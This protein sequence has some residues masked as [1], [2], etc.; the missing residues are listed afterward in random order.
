MVSLTSPTDRDVAIA[1]ANAGAKVVRNAFGSVVDEEMKGVVDPVSEVDRAAESSVIEVLTRMRPDD[2]VL[3]EE[4][5]G[6]AD[7]IGRR[8]I[9]DP[10]DGTVNFLHSIPH[11]GVSVALWDGTDPVA[12]AVIDVMRD[13]TFTAAAGEGAELDGHP[14]AVSTRDDLISCVVGTGFPYDRDQ[15]GMEY[16]TTIGHV[17]S[18]VR[19]VRRHGAAV[20]DFAWVACGRLDGF[21]E[22]NLAPWDVA[23]GLLLV[24]EAGGISADLTTEPASVTSTAFILSNSA[25]G[26]SFVEL[27]RDRT[28]GHV[29]SPN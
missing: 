3:A 13:E 10:L 9:I 11:V 14:M 19:G 6:Q 8:W 29:R 22:F 15:F 24:Q 21:W 26:D 28:P 2:G 27:I 5:G 25:L 18:R 4:G 17:L 23:A 1:A 16:A 20:L 12:C 7:P